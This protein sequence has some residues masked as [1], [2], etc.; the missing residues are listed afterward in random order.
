MMIILFNN[1]NNNNNKVK[2]TQLQYKSQTPT[3]KQRSS[4]GAQIVPNYNL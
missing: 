1:N 2:K 3:H 4:P